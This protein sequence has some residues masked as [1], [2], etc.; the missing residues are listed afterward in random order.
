MILRLA[1]FVGRE[2]IG[3]F[4]T[5]RGLTREA[6]EI[7]THRGVHARQF[8]SQWPGRLFCVD[9]WNDNLPGYEE[10]NKLLAIEVGGAGDRL[11]DQRAAQEA[12]AP[13]GWRAILMGM[14]SMSALGSFMDESLDYVHLDGDHRR[15]MVEADAFCWWRKVKLGGVMSV[16]DFLTQDP[17]AD[18]WSQEIQPAV[19]E[20]AAK[21]ELDVWLVPDDASPWS[22]FMI[23]ACSVA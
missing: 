22:A 16:H 1:P 23:K 7:G 5:A 2:N 18:R 13:F 9:P 14:T 19:L 20:F 11:L 10:Q 15:L 6:V 3:P 21:N 8:L 17:A 4:L 12:L